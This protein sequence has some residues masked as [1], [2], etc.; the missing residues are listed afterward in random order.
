[1]PTLIN[2]KVDLVSLL[3]TDLSISD[4]STA[5]TARETPQ[6]ALSPLDVLLHERK[7]RVE[8]EL[9]R[10]N[11]LL[12]EANCKVSEW[13]L[14]E[15]SCR[16]EKERELRKFGVLEK[17]IEQN[18]DQ[19]ARLNGQEPVIRAGKDPKRILQHQRQ[20]RVSNASKDFLE[21]WLKAVEGD[22]SGSA[23]TAE[24]VAASGRPYHAFNN[25]KLTNSKKNYLVPDV[26]G[27]GCRPN[28]TVTYTGIKA[29]ESFGIEV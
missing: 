9:E 5:G 28:W 1:M 18:E 4:I 8:E 2:Q 23:T 27:K 16:K 13:E 10:F 26:L 22:L 6:A 20:G 25:W 11:N 24:I 14:K 17:L 21:A 7:A 3:G 15:L 19:L 29:M 12:N